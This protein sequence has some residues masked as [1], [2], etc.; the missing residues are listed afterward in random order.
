MRR[1]FQPDGSANHGPMPL[2]VLVAFGALTVAFALSIVAVSFGIHENRH[3]INDITRVA[4]AVCNLRADQQRRIVRTEN[5]VREQ[6]RR[7]NAGLPPLQP[8]IPL[9][10]LEDDMADRRRVVEALEPLKCPPPD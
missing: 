6:R 10:L 1:V 7:Q 4:D 2:R 9:Q 3:R 8:N 5:F